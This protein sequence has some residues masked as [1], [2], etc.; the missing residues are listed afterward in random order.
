MWPMNEKGKLRKPSTDAIKLN[1]IL[2]RHFVPNFA[3]HPQV[4]R[5][6]VI[7]PVLAMI[8]KEFGVQILE[9]QINADLYRARLGDE[10]ALAVYRQAHRPNHRRR[11]AGPEEANDEEEGELEEGG[12]EGEE[13]EEAAPDD[14][15]TEPEGEGVHEGP[16]VAPWLGVAA[17]FDLPDGES[18]PELEGDGSSMCSEERF[19]ADLLSAPSVG[20]SDPDSQDTM[21]GGEFE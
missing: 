15:A 7:A 4:A 9:P 16:N 17:I 19:G 6:P 14:A 20:S 8:A 10:G 21:T 12:E 3:S 18:D 1:K 13:G 2:L 11:A 5:I